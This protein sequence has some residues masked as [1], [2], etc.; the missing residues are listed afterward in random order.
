MH[1]RTQVAQ[2]NLERPAE[3]TQRLIQL[4]NRQPL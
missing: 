2:V 1:A 3:E 4:T